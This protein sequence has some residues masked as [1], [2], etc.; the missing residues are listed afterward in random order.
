MS[1]IFQSLQS[2]SQDIHIKLVVSAIVNCFLSGFLSA[3]HLYRKLLLFSW[4]SRKVSRLWGTGSSRSCSC[5][6]QGSWNLTIFM[7]P[8]GPNHSVILWYYDSMKINYILFKLSRLFHF[9]IQCDLWPWYVEMHNIF[10]Y[11]FTHSSSASSASILN[12]TQSIHD[13]TIKK[14]LIRKLVYE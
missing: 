5:P 9:D 7:I 2:T 3:Q 4:A 1:K 13:C 8:P 10:Q 14:S 6:W 12:Q 11:I